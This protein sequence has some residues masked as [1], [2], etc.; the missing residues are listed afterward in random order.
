MRT[1]GRLGHGEFHNANDKESIA[2][3]EA[4]REFLDAVK[5]QAP[6]VL[7]TLREEVFPLY[8]EL[9]EVLGVY[10]SEHANSRLVLDRMTLAADQREAGLDF[11]QHQMYLKLHDA[12]GAWELRFHLGFDWLRRGIIYEF[13]AQS[14]DLSRAPDE[15]LEL[16]FG[17]WWFLGSAWADPVDCDVNRFSFELHPGWSPG[18]ETWDQFE[19][20]ATALFNSKLVDYRQRVEG[21]LSTHGWER[22]PVKRNDEH[23]DWAARYVVFQAKMQTLA[24]KYSISVHSVKDAVHDVLHRAQIPARGVGRPKGRTDL[25][26]PR[27]KGGSASRASTPFFEVP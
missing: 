22:V 15:R 6:E 7:T 5:R 13:A 17:R 26:S 21:Y 11:S 25:V 23:F 8:L 20:R 18:L 12:L 4:R 24:D 1:D 14:R 9:Q 27:K 10:G 19:A 3:W 16:P 2:T